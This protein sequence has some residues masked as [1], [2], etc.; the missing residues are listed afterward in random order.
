MKEFDCVVKSP[1]G[2]HARP[3]MLLARFIQ[4][5]NSDVRIK[6]KY[7]TDNAR[8]VISLFSLE[9]VQGA[10]IHFI[11]EGEDEEIATKEIKDFCKAN[12]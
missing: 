2:L 9:A 7:K 8:S 5:Y 10:R 4:K 6:Y 3:A 1:V 11:I 12:L